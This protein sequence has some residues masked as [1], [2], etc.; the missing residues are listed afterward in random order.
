[1]GGSLSVRVLSLVALCTVESGACFQILERLNNECK[2][3]DVK[4]ELRMEKFPCCGKGDGVARVRGS[5]VYMGGFK[6]IGCAVILLLRV[7]RRRKQEKNPPSWSDYI[8]VS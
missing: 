5:R 3:S 4:I 7:H 2:C 8:I 1:M 6:L